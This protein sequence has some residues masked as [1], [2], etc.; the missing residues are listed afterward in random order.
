MSDFSC[1]PFLTATLGLIFGYMWGHKNGKQD[2]IN[3]QEAVHYW[4]ERGDAKSAIRR[5]RGEIGGYPRPT[6]PR[7]PT[8]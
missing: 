5:I 8:E 1:A 6:T 3:E 4:L 2:G 7:P